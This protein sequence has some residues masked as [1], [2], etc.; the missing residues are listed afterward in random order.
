M[1][2]SESSKNDNPSSFEQTRVAWCE[3]L[4]FAI[5]E[6]ISFFFLFSLILFVS[7]VGWLVYLFFWG[8]GVVGFDYLF[9][10]FTHVFK[11][12]ISV[13][14]LSEEQSRVRKGSTHFAV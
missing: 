10:R 1:N 12:N 2:Q 5:E 6:S 8:G 14:A 7:L 4:P 11:T 13:H 3:Q 9:V